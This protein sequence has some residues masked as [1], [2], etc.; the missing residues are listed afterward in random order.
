MKLPE[1]PPRTGSPTARL[2]RPPT[3]GPKSGTHD[4]GL[5]TRGSRVVS[6]GAPT[7]RPR[8]GPTATPCS[9]SLSQGGGNLSPLGG[10]CWLVGG[11]TLGDR[12]E[13]IVGEGVIGIFRASVVGRV[14]ACVRVHCG[15]RVCPRV[16]G[17]GLTAIL[18]VTLR[19]PTGLV[20]SAPAVVGVRAARGRT[21]LPWPRVGY[22][23][24][25]S[26]GRAVADL[27]GPPE[28]EHPRATGHTG[29]QPN[30]GILGAWAVVPSVPHASACFASSPPLTAGRALPTCGRSRP[31]K[32]PR[33]PEAC[34]LRRILVLAGIAE[35][36]VPGRDG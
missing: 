4:A 28:R 5:Q 14:C 3:R 26:L 9:M 27:P 32:P 7:A 23:H 19:G 20:G 6:R 17:A 25:R 35:M 1:A 16:D 18:E 13:G 8:V 36:W 24:H 33:P 12:A 2:D 30:G 34:P 22:R 10:R 15:A 29:F 21:P 31:A 11:Q